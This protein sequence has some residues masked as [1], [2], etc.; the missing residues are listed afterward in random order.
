MFIEM[1][2]YVFPAASF[3]PK[4][5]FDYSVMHCNDLIILFPLVIPFGSYIAYLP[6]S[7]LAM[8]GVYAGMTKST[9]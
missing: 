3:H 5:L 2:K 7:M 6:T 1:V 4:S 9:N 8:R